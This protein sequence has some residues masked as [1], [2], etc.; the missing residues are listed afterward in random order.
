MKL[1]LKL[2]ELTEMLL[3]LLVFTRLLYA[4]W[5]LLALF[6]L[7]ALSMVGYWAGPRAGA[8]CYN[9]AHHKALALL[10]GVGGWWLGQPLLLLA[11]TV[12][13]LHSAFD[14]LLGTALSSQPAS[15]TRIWGAWESV[16]R[17]ALN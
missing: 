10:V 14:W 4:W 3:A 16:S 13:L 11:G 5:M 7:P 12:L 2:E 6:P 17:Q 8:F 1:L 9:L 15:G